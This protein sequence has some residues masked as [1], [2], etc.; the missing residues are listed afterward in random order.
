MKNKNGFIFMETIVVISVLS[1]T[2][3]LLFASYSYILRKSRTKKMFDTTETI[4]KT[5]YVKQVIDN[6]KVTNNGTGIGIE[7]YIKTH[8]SGANPECKQ[9]ATS[10]ICDLSS[11][12]Y[13]GDL[14]Q[15]KHIF[16]IDKFYYLNPNT[17]INANNSNDIL[18]NFDA[19][20]IDYIKNLG[21]GVDSNVFIIKYKKIYSDGTYE[22]YH[23]S[24]EVNS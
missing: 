8:L 19:T 10:Y 5:Y 6:Y 11:T 3:L 9:I 21:T 4:Y 12:D 2:L 23:S 1:I 20:T 24:M 7:Y 13:K 18:N 17:V 14:Y 16:E 22:V 15:I